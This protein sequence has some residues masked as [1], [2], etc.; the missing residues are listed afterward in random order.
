M[1][2]KL[3]LTIIAIFAF[4]GVLGGCGKQNAAAQTQTKGR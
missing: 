2:K 3:V 4:A 1:K